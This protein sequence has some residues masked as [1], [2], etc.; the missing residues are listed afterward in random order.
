MAKRN[1]TPKE[2]APVPATSPALL[3]PLK[4]DLDVNNAA[5]L[6]MHELCLL[7]PQASDEDYD[8][9][10]GSM[11][12]H[13]FMRDQAI[14]LY[15]EPTSVVDP[16]QRSETP[17]VLDGRNRLT[18]ALDAGVTPKFLEYVGEDALGFVLARN[19]AR[20][21]LSSGQRAALGSKLATLG[22]GANQFTKGPAVTQKEAAKKADT[23][24]TNIAKF[25][26][27]QEADPKLAK[28]VEDGEVTP[29]KAYKQVRAP[30]PGEGTGQRPSEAKSP[31]GDMTK[32]TG[33][34]DKEFDPSLDIKV[35]SGG[36]LPDAAPSGEVGRVRP[37]WQVNVD[38][39]PW[40][41]SEDGKFKRDH[42]IIF[43]GTRM[44]MVRLNVDEATALILQ[45]HEAVSK[46]V[47]QLHPTE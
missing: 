19:L 35:P 40:D 30:A 5:N 47:V 25:R 39:G 28:K 26:A 43:L 4:D 20:R 14:I 22:V 29:D 13:G 2:V 10:V 27:V 17:K 45:L 34:K 3:A 18:A 32:P 24:E 42:P 41:D 11:K 33:S 15:Y 31:G 7:F 37:T 16:E 1:A 44:N 12:T 23:N 21:H 6:E 36:T 46:F 8:S 38:R 9:L